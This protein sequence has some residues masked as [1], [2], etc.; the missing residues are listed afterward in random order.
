[1]SKWTEVF[2]FINKL[3]TKVC[4]CCCFFQCNKDIT[5]DYMQQCPDE[6]NTAVVFKDMVIVQ[7]DKTHSA[8]SGTIDFRKTIGEP[9]KVNIFHSQSDLCSA[10]NGTS[11]RQ[12]VE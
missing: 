12:F 8:L 4:F 11:L 1:M 3:K 7:T 2:K 10:F 9:W 6:P 5:V